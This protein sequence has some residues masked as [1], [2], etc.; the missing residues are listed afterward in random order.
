MAA[1]EPTNGKQATPHGAVPA[2]RLSGVRTAR[3]E[4]AAPRAEQRAQPPLVA[5]DEREQQA[6]HAGADPGAGE[7]RGTMPRAK[8]RS[9][10][11]ASSAELARAAPGRART[12]SPVA[13][14][15]ES[16]RA[17]TR[18]RS[19]RR[20]RFRTTAGPTFRPTAKPTR[21]PDPSREAK[22]RT[23]G[24][25]DTRPPRAAAAKSPRRRIRVAAG[26]TELPRSGR[27]PLAALATPG[28]EDGAAGSRAH[29]QPK[30]MGLRPT[31]VVR[32]KGPLAHR[33][34]PQSRRIRQ[35]N[36]GIGAA[37]Y[38]TGGRNIGQTVGR[39]SNRATVKATRRG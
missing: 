1:A 9:K 21:I 25:L 12:T 17:R 3:G 37:T 7:R 29:A 15:M 30:A 26:S 27:Q 18:W 39:R 19:W 28:G 6:A 34:T 13:S 36:A 24:G 10:A 11:A 5:S 14:G 35:A 4:E 20:M 16:N 2:D 33:K 31:T 22:C 8:P 23:S 38:G 32:L